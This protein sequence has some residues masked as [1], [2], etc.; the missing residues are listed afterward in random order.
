MIPTLTV[1]FVMVQDFDI[2]LEGAQTLRILCYKI[3]NESSTLIGKGAFEVYCHI[4]LLVTYFQIP[5]LILTS[6]LTW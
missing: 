6:Q 3:E 1:L 5:K 4:F 2:D